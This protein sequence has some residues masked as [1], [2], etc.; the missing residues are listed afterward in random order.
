MRAFSKSQVKTLLN[1]FGEKLIIVLN[2]VETEYT[3]LYEH[4]EF[5]FE[6]TQTVE[7]YF[8]AKEGI[9]LHTTFIKDGTE[10]QV[11]RI[12]DDLS[13]ISNYYYIQNIDLNEEI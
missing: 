7:S 5:F 8:S 1:A 11:N 10:Y 3:V 6:G 13:G 2:G 9:P 12:E 4:D